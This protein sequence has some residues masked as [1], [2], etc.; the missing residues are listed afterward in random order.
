MSLSRAFLEMCEKCEAPSVLTEGVLNRDTLGMPFSNAS[1][2]KVIAFVGEKG[3]KEDLLHLYKS[4]IVAPYRESGTVP[5]LVLP[6]KIVKALSD[7]GEPDLALQ[8]T[9]E[10]A[11]N[12]LERAEALSAI[13]LVAH[14]DP[15]KEDESPAEE[16]PR[17]E[18]E[19]DADDTQ[20]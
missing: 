4:L 2:G 16:P 5:P 7:M 19:G 1:L 10:M 3:T 18:G 11:L 13:V 14:E 9:K 12:G 15:H 20:K 17:D 6:Y 8:L